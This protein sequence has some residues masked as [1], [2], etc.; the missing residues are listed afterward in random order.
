LKKVLLLALALSGC[1]TMIRSPLELKPCRVDGVAE[2][3]LCGSLPVPEDRSD[4]DSR[5]ISLKIVVLPAKGE[6]TLPPLYDLPGGPG[7]PATASAGFWA[8]PGSVHRAHRDVVLVDQRGTGGSAALDCPVT[9]YDPLNQV[10]ALHTI[11]D[12]RTQLSARADL[13]QYTTSAAIADLDAVR[14]ALGHDRIDLTGLSYGTRL[15]QE[16]VRAHPQRVRA[17]ALIGTVTPTEKLPLSFSTNAQTVLER[18]S[19]QCASDRNCHAAIENLAGDAAV[20]KNTLARGGVNTTRKDGRTVRVEAGP[21]MEA[22]R[23]QLSSTASQRRLPWLLHQA[24]YGDLQPLLRVMTGPAEP[25]SNG[26]LLSVS[27]AEDT[28]RITAEEIASLSATV[29]GSYRVQ[30]QI[31]ACRVWRVPIVENPGPPFVKTDVP[32]LLI[33]GDMDAVTPVD[34]AH[35]VASHMA[36]GRVVVI[37]NLGHVP[38]GL[39]NIDCLDRIIGEFFAAGSA[40]NLDLECVKS[41]KPPAFDV[42]AAPVKPKASKAEVK[43]KKK[44]QVKK[45]G[46]GKKKALKKTPKKKR[47]KA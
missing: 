8:G 4:P 35:K 7:I 37:P 9:F 45:K 6:K 24:A 41:M 19:Q 29:F 22:L 31:A 3:L 36:N 32:T 44:A 12:C 46:K 23:K 34:W 26:L 43:K 13:S 39:S 40:A 28:V 27:C 25:G 17:M 30:R 14:A 38:E 21:F 10:L 2:P 1:A 33:A 47:K 20:L 42:P 16:Y 11:A 5:K 15:A 18:L